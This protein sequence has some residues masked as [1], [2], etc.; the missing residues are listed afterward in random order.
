MKIL[1]VASIEEHIRAFHMP[2][3][4]DMIDKGNEV[5][6]YSKNTSSNSFEENGVEFININFTRA[7]LTWNS[8]KVFFQLFK[9][10]K[11]EKF[12]LIS[13]HTPTASVLIRAAAFFSRSKAKIIYTAHGFHFF[14]G[15]PIKN[16]IIFYWLEKILAKATDVLFVM[17]DEDFKISQKFKL[18]ANG[19]V[20]KIPGIG[21]NLKKYKKLDEK[22]VGKI[23]ENLQ[24]K[25]NELMLISVAELSYRKNQIQLLK[26]LENLGG[27]IKLFLVGEGEKREEYKKFIEK[28]GLNEK[29]KLL[30]VRSDINELINASDLVCL[31]SIH[32]GLPR[33]ILEA[34]AI[35]KPA[36]V[37]D[38]R[39]NNDL[40]KHL[41]NG[42]VVPLNNIKMTKEMIEY[43]YLNKNYLKEMGLK[44]LKII[45]NY[46][47]E[48][49][50]DMIGKIVL[51]KN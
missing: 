44:N 18:R 11:I 47:E 5:K 41:E 25:E 19:E 29:V 2:I 49:V 20:K 3:I 28:N 21:I 8:L 33:C 23:R 14:K 15:A 9:L 17:N 36:L 48:I 34:M 4:K 22:M 6:V 10:L 35:G 40:I 43:S 51:T 38:I 45:E 12:D 7:P 13:T 37:S 42:L 31:T 26:A 1:Y 46:R 27:N 30:G 39:G 24:V 32:E 16:W 50:I